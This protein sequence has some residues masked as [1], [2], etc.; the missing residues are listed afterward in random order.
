LLDGVVT[1]EVAPDVPPDLLLGQHLVRVDEQM[2]QQPVLGERQ[3]QGPRP[4]PCAASGVVEDE[5]AVAELAITVA[6]RAA[7]R[8]MVRAA[9]QYLHPGQDLGHTERFGDVVPLPRAD[10]GKE[11][12]EG[13]ARRQE[14]HR[15]PVLGGRAAQSA[16]TRQVRHRGVEDDE[17]VA[18]LERPRHRLVPVPTRLIR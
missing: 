15:R 14:Q 12:D 3:I 8:A 6:A 7:V 17:V 18:A 4:A 10:F 2:P 16:Q 5:V 13:V 9:Q 11:L 1:A